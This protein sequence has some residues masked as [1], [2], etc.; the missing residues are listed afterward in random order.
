MRSADIGK[1][2]ENIA[3]RYLEEQGYM[4]LERNYRFE[5]YEIDLACYDPTGEEIVFV[6]VKTRSGELFG[7]PAEAVTPEKQ[8]RIA[9]VAEIFLHEKQL[10]NAPA[11]FDVISIILQKN[12]PP[13]I[14]HI[15]HAFFAS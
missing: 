8:A 6:E 7:D 1:Y 3:A 14:E 4:I 10:L 15:K 12:R 11:R 2:G 9:R 5:R 13:Q